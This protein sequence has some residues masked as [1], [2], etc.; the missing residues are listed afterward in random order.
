MK[1][2]DAAVEKA[3]GFSKWKVEFN[4]CSQGHMYPFWSGTRVNVIVTGPYSNGHA[5]PIRKVQAVTSLAPGTRPSCFNFSSYCGRDPQA[6]PE[7][8]DGE[9]HTRT[10]GQ[11]RD[12]VNETNRA[13]VNSRTTPVATRQGKQQRRVQ[14]VG[15]Y[16][17]RS[18]WFETTLQLVLH[19]SSR[20]SQALLQLWHTRNLCLGCP[21]RTRGGTCYRCHHAHLACASSVVISHGLF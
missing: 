6:Q 16:P 18:S 5:G 11:E 8:V 20:V 4:F 7:L 19:R 15:L 12:S 1:Q 17:P 2:E 21:S 3:A 14:V 13:T 10:C 9:N